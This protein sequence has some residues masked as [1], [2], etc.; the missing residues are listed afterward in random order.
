MSSMARIGS[1][2]KR[3]T[4][5]ISF[6]FGCVLLGLLGLTSANLFPDQTWR[7]FKAA[8]T[9]YDGNVSPLTPMPSGTDRNVQEFRIYESLVRD[10]IK[11]NPSSP[12]IFLSVDGSDPSDDLIGR[13]SASG[14]VVK[15]V[16]EAHLDTT[17][18]IWTDHSSGSE[19]V[20]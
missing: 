1:V 2:R 17:K 5:A 16:S 19:A 7:A 18:S 20:R 15:R 3:V 4:P 11:S 10:F 9:T 6:T 14:L 13:F 8:R 12:L